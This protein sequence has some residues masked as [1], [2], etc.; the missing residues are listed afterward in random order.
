MTVIRIMGRLLAAVALA[1]LAA[2]GSDIQTTSGR[3]YLDAY[4]TPTGADATSGESETIDAKVRRVA[5]VEPTLRFPARIG[6]ARIENGELSGMSSAEAAAWMAGAERLGPAFGEFV[7]LS[8]LVAEM[9]TN[10]T[11][12]AAGQSLVPAS[13]LHRTMEKIRLGAAR[14]HLDV[15]L[16]YEV[17]GRSNQSGNP[18]SVLNLT[19]IGAFLLPGETIDAVGFASALL[20]DVRNGYPY[21]T[22]RHVVDHG[23]I[24]PSVGSRNERQ[25]L[26]R[27]AMTEA[28]VGLVPEVETMFRRLHVAL[29][30]L[31]A[32]TR[33]QE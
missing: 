2:C 8:R 4:E 15:V 14:Q 23:A 25:Q 31:D 21:G 30:Q 29:S 10:P 12:E 33:T 32:P 13:R 3:A 9:V 6:L 26:M 5:A 20:L 28:A 24:T 16:V 11:N 17:Y 18:L 27:S 19:I 1:T 22:A 7:P